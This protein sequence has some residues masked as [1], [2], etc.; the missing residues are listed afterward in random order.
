[1]QPG[2]GLRDW[3]WCLTAQVATR[4]PCSSP[5]A[6]SAGWCRCSAT[7]VSPVPSASSSSVACSSARGARRPAPCACMYNWGGEGAGPQ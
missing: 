7:R 2:L 3:G 5:A 6:T 4:M 1:M